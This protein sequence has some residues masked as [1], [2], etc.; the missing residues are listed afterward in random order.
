MITEVYKCLFTYSLSY[1]EAAVCSHWMRVVHGCAIGFFMD[2][3][4]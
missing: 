3:I 4:C 2:L 1:M